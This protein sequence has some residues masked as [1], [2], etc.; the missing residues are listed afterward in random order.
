MR[1]NLLIVIKLYYE[2]EYWYYG[3]AGIDSVWNYVSNTI[4]HNF[5]LPRNVF[6]ITFVLLSYTNRVTVWTLR[7][8]EIRAHD[9]CFESTP[10]KIT[11]LIRWKIAVSQIVL[12]HSAHWFLI[13]SRLTTY[14]YFKRDWWLHSYE[15]SRTFESV[16][17]DKLLITFCT[18]HYWI[19][20]T[21]LILSK[22]YYYVRKYTC[23]KPEMEISPDS[24]SSAET[25]SLRQSVEL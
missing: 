10:I 19:T 12:T 1:R 11:F 9:K 21:P 24:N 8:I 23:L 22:L 2:Y 3:P 7:H 25:S 6:W 14:T 17:I 15:S 5:R 4:Q 13:V 20:H 18:R 16:R